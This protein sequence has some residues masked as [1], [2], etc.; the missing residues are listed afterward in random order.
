MR[1]PT[2]ADLHAS[3]Q[4]IR[5]NADKAKTYEPALIDQVQAAIEQNLDTLRQAADLRPGANT[6]R[7]R[8]LGQCGVVIDAI[9]RARRYPEQII[10]RAA[11]LDQIG[12]LARMARDLLAELEEPRTGA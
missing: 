7:E 8:T 10:A 5:Q 12:A 11:A 2:E 6:R 9:K 4:A 1:A 3:L